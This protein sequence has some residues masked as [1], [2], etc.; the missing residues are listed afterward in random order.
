M[1]KRKICILLLN[2]KTSLLFT[3][4]V[5][6]AL[7]LMVTNISVV[8]AQKEDAEGIIQLK[9]KSSQDALDVYSDAAKFQNGAKFEIAVEEWEAF[10]KEFQDDPLAPKAIYYLGI[11]ALQLQQY[12]KAASAFEFTATRY[13]PHDST[14]PALF[15]W[16][17][18]RYAQASSLPDLK[19]KQ[20]QLKTAIGA[21]EKQLA[22]H[23]KGTLAD[24][25][26]YLMGESHYGLGDKP[27]A[28][29]S[30]QAV[31]TGFPKSKQRVTAVY[32]LGATL[33]EEKKYVEAGKA[34]DI[35][36]AEF[37]EDPLRTEIRMRKAETILQ[38]KNYQ[39][40]A[41]VFGEVAA[42]EDYA[43]ADHSRMRQAFCL[44]QLKQ[45]EEATAI[46][47]AVLSAKETAG[48]HIEAAG[49]LLSICRVYINDKKHDRALELADTFI[50]NVTDAELI[51]QVK[52]VAADALDGQK[53]YDDSRQ[54]YLGIVEQHSKHAL[55][56]DALYFAAF[57]ALQLQ[58]HD[59]VIADAKTFLGK[60]PKHEFQPDVVKLLEESRILKSAD[61]FKDKKH[62]EVVK[63]L[64]ASIKDNP[65]G[66]R[67]VDSLL[68][69]ARS[70]AALKEIDAA[71]GYAA[72][73]IKDFPESK[74]VAE[75]QFRL[76]EYHYGAKEYALAI[77]QYATVVKDHSD[78][79]FVANSLYSQAW[80]E[81]LTDKPDVAET[82]FSTLI[83]KHPE[84]Q[85]VSVALLGR[86]KVRR[87]QK[88][89][90]E[91][92]EDLDGFLSSQPDVNQQVD[93][94]S[95]KGKS[96]IGLQQNA[97]AIET[98]NLLLTADA[99]Y[100]DADAILYEIAF[101]Q[102]TLDKHDAAKATFAKLVAE[103]ADST[104]A[105]D[106]HFRLAEY[107]YAAGQFKT[108]LV[109]YSKAASSSQGSDAL[110]EN[111]L[112][113][114]AWTHYKLDDFKESAA[115]FKNQVSKYAAG[116][117]LHDGQFM[118]AESLY[119]L[120]DFQAA[121]AAFGAITSVTF[122]SPQQHLLVRLHGGKAT[123]ELKQYEQ[124][125]SLLQ[126]VVD[127]ED[128]VADGYR[129]E[130]HFEIGWTYDREQNY[131]K[132]LVA[133]AAAGRD[134]GHIGARA[135]F[136]IGDIAFKQKQFI[137]AI[138]QFDRTILRFEDENAPANVKE[139]QALA[140][141]EAGRCKEVLAGVAKDDNKPD[142]MK[143][144]VSEAITYYQMIIDKYPATELV[145]NA[146]ERV[147]ELGKIE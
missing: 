23:A 18:T 92:I 73:L 99:K 115:G 33:E 109:D 9:E 30:Y 62:A 88:K 97:A 51:I 116:S 145:K 37:P 15:Y 112:H 2:L 122:K 133:F 75:A 22:A 120:D 144:L 50:A 130:A 3:L 141:F 129:R 14:E 12:D 84:H 61:L 36:L 57:A 5:T 41:E 114:Q 126:Q 90:K 8:C 43:L 10:Q 139:Y 103:H 38:A 21:F 35:F 17:R 127:S 96:Q 1:F 28:I 54:R 63:I 118:F 34:Y 76:G 58:Q 101:A 45:Y 13:A 31:V 124:A 69:L 19:Q 135:H 100:A 131:E 70:S 48:F 39:E 104:L 137:E 74:L 26:W 6:L 52:L 53:K 94:W 46:F 138:K 42:V 24:Q 65:Q 56:A 87:Q 67:V 142:E 110:K 113:K 55:A 40:A 95:E 11:C 121:A 106:A 7:T 117:F 123:S 59:D 91:A 68:L 49:H 105:G 136:M 89:F 147:A 125:R 146:M 77:K 72:R 143:K 71:K 79:V 32:A 108:A 119:K 128:E 78:S 20:A 132:A 111:I 64:S 83:E 82:T 93:A 80:S 140:A 44:L 60:Y 29:K 98:F 102:R 134:R 47:S 25:A 66:S 85:L 27:A 107:Q 81:V 16:G 86:G 4:F